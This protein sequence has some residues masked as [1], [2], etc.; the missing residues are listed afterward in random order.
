MEAIKPIEDCPFVR[1]EKVMVSEG[2][3][4]YLERIFLAYIEGAEEKYICVAS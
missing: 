2:E 4:V 3:V 1:G